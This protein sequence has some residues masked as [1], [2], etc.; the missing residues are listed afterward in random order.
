MGLS[1]EIVA[2]ILDAVRSLLH[3]NATLSSMIV[4]C[5]SSLSLLVK[6]GEI[7]SAVTPQKSDDE[8]TVVH[9][10]YGECNSVHLNLTQRIGQ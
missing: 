8:F 10:L 2:N 7:R 9:L 3:V 6:Y 1:A 5:A 4:L